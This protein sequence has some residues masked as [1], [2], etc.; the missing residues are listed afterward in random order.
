MD[1]TPLTQ[2]GADALRAELTRLKKT[3][4]PRI[5]AAIEEARGGSG[6]AEEEGFR[7]GQGLR[8][9]QRLRR[10]RLSPGRQVARGSRIRGR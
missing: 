4:R 3:E 1:R 6:A 8:V 9:V 10:R 2:T 7:E 5:V